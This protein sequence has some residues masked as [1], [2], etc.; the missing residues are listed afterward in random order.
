MNR[1]KLTISRNTLRIAFVAAL[2]A[3]SIALAAFIATPAIA[4]EGGSPLPSEW[5]QSW[6]KKLS[7]VVR[8]VVDIDCGAILLDD[9]HLLTAAHCVENLDRSQEFRIENADSEGSDARY[10]KRGSVFLHPNYPVGQFRTNPRQDFA[11][12][13]IAVVRLASSLKRETAYP[14]LA[15]RPLPLKS[16]LT[17][18]ANG[19]GVDGEST[20][21]RVDTYEISRGRL[22]APESTTSSAPGQ[23]ISFISSLAL[24]PGH[25]VCKGDSGAGYFAFNREE[26]Q[27]EIMAIQSVRTQKYPCDHSQNYGFVAPVFENLAWIKSILESAKR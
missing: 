7:P 10:K 23:L 11:L 20:P 3:T 2:L 22:P 4:M 12:S 21:N 1:P 9:R 25:G 5:T 18:L 17:L 14:V 26:G 8:I 24:T 27:L 13:D 15:R 16:K 19:T 6:G